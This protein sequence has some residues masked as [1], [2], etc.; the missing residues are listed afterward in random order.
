MRARVSFKRPE[1]GGRKSGPPP[2]DSFGYRVPV[3]LEDGRPI[4]GGKMY[5]CRFKWIQQWDEGY[6]RIAEIEF[7]VREVED[8]LGIDEQLVISEDGRS[9]HGKMRII[10]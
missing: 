1:E 8:H 5:T 4:L 10:Q 2:F 7:L 3:G 9:V 6:E